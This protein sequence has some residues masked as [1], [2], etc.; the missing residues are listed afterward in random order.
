MTEVAVL[1]DQTFD[2]GIAGGTVLV[3]FWAQWCGPCHALAPVLDELAAEAAGARVAKV[4][5][6]EF[7]AIGE[8]F[9]ITSLPTLIVFRDGQPVKKLF[10]AKNKRQLTRALTEAAAPADPGAPADLASPSA[11]ASSAAPAA[12]PAAR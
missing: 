1:T 5:V 9:G 11:P 12:D 6:A 8:R 4:D 2:D 7:P 10:G 3:D